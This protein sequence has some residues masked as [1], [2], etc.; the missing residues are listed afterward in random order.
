MICPK[1][2]EPRLS[3]EKCNINGKYY[4]VCPVCALLMINKAHKLSADT[5]FRG[6]IAQQMYDD[7]IEYQN[8]RKGGRK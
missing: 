5:P 8:I 6:E 2:E 3:V 1:C 4:N 7:E